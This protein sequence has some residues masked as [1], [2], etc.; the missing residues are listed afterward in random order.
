MAK[1]FGIIGEVQVVVENTIQVIKIFKI[2]NGV[3]GTGEVISIGTMF[4]P[5]V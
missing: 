2:L 5:S 1:E 4:L 3:F